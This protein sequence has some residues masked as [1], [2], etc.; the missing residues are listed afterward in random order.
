MIPL[1]DRNPTRSSPFV[2]YVLVAINV[3][4]YLYELALAPS[5]Q[6]LETFYY[7]FGVV[8]AELLSGR[9]VPPLLPVGP[10]YL[11]VLTSLFVHGGLLH[12]GGNML[13]LWIFGNNVE[14]RLGHLRFL[15]FYLV[16]G[17]AAAMA[18][19][20]L[21]A[22]SR[23]PMIGASGAV[24]GVLGAYLVLFPSARITTLL[25][26]GFFITVLQVPALLLIGYWFLLQ[27]LNGFFSLVLPMGEGGTAW[28]AHIGGF[29]A[30]ILLLR[31]FRPWPRRHAWG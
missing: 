5:P 24:A 19:I 6:A 9:D 14:D 4:V 28:F 30:G 20:A 11:T 10:V 29:V 13:Y 18:Q 8:P 15:L 23:Y 22:D 1:Y 16:C 2:T 12:V 17:S 3:L 27:V 31:L 26:L 7:R 25:F 21:S